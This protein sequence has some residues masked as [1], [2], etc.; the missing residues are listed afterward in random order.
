[1][2]PINELLTAVGPAPLCPSVKVTMKKQL[3]LVTL[4]SDAS[5]SKKMQEYTKAKSN[6][7]RKIGC[8][9][10]TFLKLHFAQK[11]VHKHPELKVM[12]QETYDSVLKRG[13][14]GGLHNLYFLRCFL[15]EFDK[16]IQK[17]A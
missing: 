5:D 9:L 7:D 13:I 2:Y 4:Y 14:K 15:F 6:H 11:G 12:I 16:T 1:M 3:G 17:K 8:L 10:N